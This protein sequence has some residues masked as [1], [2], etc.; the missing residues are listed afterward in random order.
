MRIKYIFACA[1]ALIFTVSGG[2]VG[3]QSADNKEIS[4]AGACTDLDFLAGN[5]VVR[6]ADGTSDAT[7]RVKLGA[8]HCYGTEF[9]SFGK[10]LGGGRGICFL[11]YSNQK[12][13]WAHI[14]GVGAG[15][16]YRFAD[17]RLYGNEVRFAG[18]DMADGMT[19]MFT[20]VRLSDK[21]VHEMVKE[22]HDGGNTW[23]S[24]ADEYWSREK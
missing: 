20:L 23:K 15:D 21:R 13:N 22:S 12:H 6:G 7:V 19:Q 14:C 9:W 1:F 5:W 24:L 16:R 11:A 4:A 17:G 2:H 18:E 10:G 8:G 3:A